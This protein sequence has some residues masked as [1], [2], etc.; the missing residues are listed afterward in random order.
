MS[1]I[2]SLEFQNAKYPRNESSTNDVSVIQSFRL[3]F[4]F[5]NSSAVLFLGQKN[6]MAQISTSD[7]FPTNG[8]GL[9]HIIR[10][11]IQQTRGN[12]DHRKV[13][14]LPRNVA[15]TIRPRHT[16]HSNMLSS[17]N[18][19]KGSIP[20]QYALGEPVYCFDQRYIARI[21]IFRSWLICLYCLLTSVRMSWQREHGFLPAMELRGKS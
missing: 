15:A 20:S 7:A 19:L 18:F 11:W 4:L 10:M 8:V 9:R 13:E 17:F 14:K 2:H 6:G 16:S 5:L 3:S 1:P 12:D 21:Q